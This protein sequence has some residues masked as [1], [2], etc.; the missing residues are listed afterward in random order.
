MKF[1]LLLNV[2]YHCQTIKLAVGTMAESVHTCS[3]DSFR[4]L[5]DQ[6]V[7]KSQVIKSNPE[8]KL[9]SNWL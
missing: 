4:N 7:I 2:L 3:K 9:L 5:S 8:I 6:T 1:P